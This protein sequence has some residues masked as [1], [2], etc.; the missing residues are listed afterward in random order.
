MDLD[1]FCK[2]MKVIPRGHDHSSFYTFYEFTVG[3]ISDNGISV[4]DFMCKYIFYLST[5]CAVMSV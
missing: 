4:T 3:S 2:S 1:R 5:N